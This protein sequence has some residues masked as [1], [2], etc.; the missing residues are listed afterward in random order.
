MVPFAIVS[1]MR[2]GST[3]L[4]RLVS[5][6]PCVLMFGELLHKYHPWYSPHVDPHLRMYPTPPWRSKW[7]DPEHRYWHLVD[8]LNDVYSTNATYDATGFKFLGFQRKWVAHC[9]TNVECDWTLLRR[10]L[11]HNATVRKIVLRRTNATDGFLSFKH[12][13]RTGDWKGS[14]RA[15]AYD[16]RE[17]TEWVREQTA[18]YETVTQDLTGQT[19]LALSERDLDDHRTVGRIRS[20]LALGC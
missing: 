13:A 10:A 7:K 14:G 8:F 4:V 12:A 9:A 3:A 19:Y 15:T 1:E 20:F 17:L 2:S 16:A 5:K 6:F 11:L 18:Y